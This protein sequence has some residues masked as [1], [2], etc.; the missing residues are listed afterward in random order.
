M[1]LNRKDF[2]LLSE[3]LLIVSPEFLVRK[4]SFDRVK[5]HLPICPCWASAKCYT[6][7]KF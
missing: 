5:D 6:S 4:L 1:F 7:A 2:S 3:Q